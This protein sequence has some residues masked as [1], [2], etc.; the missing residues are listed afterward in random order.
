[1]KQPGPATSGSTGA[2]N[3]GIPFP[4]LQRRGSPTHSRMLAMMSVCLISLPPE[5]L[6]RIASRN[7][8]GGRRGERRIA[9]WVLAVAAAAGVI[10]ALIA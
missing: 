5:A 1:M 4:D 8:M 10:G 6:G 3:P 9:L 7:A 2:D